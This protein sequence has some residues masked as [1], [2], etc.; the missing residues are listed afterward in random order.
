MFSKFK[1]REGEYD[2][3]EVPEVVDLPTYCLKNYLEA[4]K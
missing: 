1:A 3:L 2:S 4:K